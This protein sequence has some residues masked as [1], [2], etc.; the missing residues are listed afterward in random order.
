MARFEVEVGLP[1]VETR[2]EGIAVA[3]PDTDVVGEIDQEV[4]MVVVE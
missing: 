4:R 1:V 3:E 2:D